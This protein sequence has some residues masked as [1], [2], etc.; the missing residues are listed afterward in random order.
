MSE[1]QQ[2]N[3]NNQEGV[4]EDKASQEG[5][6][7]MCAFLSYLLIGIVWYFA[8][9]TMKK[10]E[11]AKF[12]TKQALMLMIVSIVGS[13]VLGLIPILGWLMLPFFGLFT[14]V[15]G[16]IGIINALNGEKK[17]L[18]IIGGYADKLFKF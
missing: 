4:I 12:H 14:L 15:L 2:V 8:D 13:F 1:E 11:F 9:A 7:K 6:G 17:E 5:N 18:V 3:E 10:N 16:I